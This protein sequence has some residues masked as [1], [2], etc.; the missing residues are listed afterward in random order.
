MAWKISLH[1]FHQLKM[2]STW[3]KFDKWKGMSH[4]RLNETRVL[5]VQ[6]LHN[7]INSLHL[8]KHILTYT[9]SMVCVWLG[10][11]GTSSTC[12]LGRT[13][14]VPLALPVSISLDPSLLCTDTTKKHSHGTTCVLVWMYMKWCLLKNDGSTEVHM[15]YTYCKLPL[16]CSIKG[17]A[18]WLD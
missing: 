4:S 18:K 13:R 14:K 10:C 7:G 12:A 17:P 1:C 2:G 3:K 16:I 8:L 5:F 6:S 11:P 15:Y 9:I